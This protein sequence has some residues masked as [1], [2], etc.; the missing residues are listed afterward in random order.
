MKH[1]FGPLS[2]VRAPRGSHQ[3]TCPTTALHVSSMSSL[4]KKDVF[5]R[6]CCFAMPHEN[7]GHVTV[8]KDS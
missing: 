6:F 1:P 4:D 7:L 8:L 2:A 3:V 5:L